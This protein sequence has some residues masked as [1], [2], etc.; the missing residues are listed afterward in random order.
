M[1]ARGGA[2]LQRLQP[3]SQLARAQRAD[4]VVVG[5]RLQGTDDRVFV[6]PVGNHHDRHFAAPGAAHRAHGF[7]GRHVGELVVDQQDVV[8]GLVDATEQFPA[9][10]IGVAIHAGAR[11]GVCDRLGLKRQIR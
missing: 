8:A 7:Q 2:A 4:H 6:A 9:C 3:G 1:P 10:V 11:E 5:A